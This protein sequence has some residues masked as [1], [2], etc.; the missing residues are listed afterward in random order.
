[1]PL[2]M[3]GGKN[4]DT[5]EYIELGTSR[6]FG[7]YHFSAASLDYLETLIPRGARQQE[8]KQHLWRGSKSPIEKG[9]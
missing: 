9:P 4:G 6:G 7:S 5:L 3:V 1:M 2:D 8:G